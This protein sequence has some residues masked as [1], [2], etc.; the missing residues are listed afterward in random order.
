MS[1]PRAA[2]PNPPSHITGE[3]PAW[4]GW[5]VSIGSPVTSMGKMTDVPAKSCSWRQQ[6][7]SPCGKS[8]LPLPRPTMA[9]WVEET[10]SSRAE[11]LQAVW[12]PFLDCYWQQ[13][14]YIT[15]KAA[16]QKNQPLS[17]HFWKKICGGFPALS[18][19]PEHTISHMINQGKKVVLF[20][21]IKP[22]FVGRKDT[23]ICLGAHI[24]MLHPAGV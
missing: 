10:P 11:A 4:L 2:Q 24:Q 17:P 13:H 21:E 9:R 19:V 12:A 15:V 7:T 5:D 1:H 14:L 16:L 18:V 22:Q 6:C 20:T 23:L 8:C 3:A